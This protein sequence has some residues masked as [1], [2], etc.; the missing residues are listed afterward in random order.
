MAKD[1]LDNLEKAMQSA[2]MIETTKPEKK[3]AG[4][5][6]ITIGEQKRTIITYP[7]EWEERILAKAETIGLPFSMNAFIRQAMLEKMEREGI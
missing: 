2:A 6:K 5:K 3:K 7:V 1:K 4:R